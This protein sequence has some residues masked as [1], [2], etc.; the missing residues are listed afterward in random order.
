MQHFNTEAQ[1]AAKQRVL[2]SNLWHLARIKAEQLYSPIY[3]VPWGYRF[4]ARLLVR[5]ISKKR[6]VLIGFHERKSSLIADIHQCEILPPHVSTLL[7]PLRELIGGLSILASIPQV[8][9][10]V[11]DAITALVLR[12]MELIN[13]ADEALLRVFADRHGVVF[14]CSRALRPR[15]DFIR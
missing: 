11:C 5:V 15:L 9:L 6:G 7:R 3:G 8:E 1:V 2:E 13:P 4:R 14:T 12:I 10:T